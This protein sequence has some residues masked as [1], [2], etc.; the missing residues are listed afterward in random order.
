M[1]E[2]QRDAELVAAAPPQDGADVTSTLLALA[3]P[4]RQ[5]VVDLLRE[6]P[7]RAGELAVAA[8]VSPAALSRHLRVLRTSGLVEVDG[9]GS[10]ARLRVYRLRRPPFM[11]LQAWLDQVHA[12]WGEHLDAFATHANRVA[13]RRTAHSGAAG[14]G[15]ERDR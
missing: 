4:T 15:K 2:V 10:D 11:A 1:V 6:R 14:G 3:D 12:F 7:R 13:D 5:R 9:V 8:Q